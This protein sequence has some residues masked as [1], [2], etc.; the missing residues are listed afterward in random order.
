[1]PAKVLLVVHQQH[2]DPGRIGETLSR[3]GLEL[4]LRRPSLGDP[5]PEHLDDHQGAVIFGGPM[6]ANDDYL[7]FIRT[8]L[9]WIGVALNSGKPFLGICLGA[10]LLARHLGAKV[11]A[12]PNG[13]HEIGYY[14]LHATADGRDFV[15]P[16]FHAFEWHG[17]G[18][19][20]PSGAS[21]LATGRHFPHQAFRYGSAYGLQFH[22]EV[23][24]T[25]MERW[26]TRASHKLGFRGAQCKAEQCALRETHD[27]EMDRWVAGFL[28]RWLRSN[29]QADP[30]QNACSAPPMA[31][32][33]G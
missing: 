19:D 3:M 6:S 31:A 4:D 11:R 17:E 24:R 33:G 16:G 29:S 7:D 25:I 10:Q 20:M 28:P 12:H 5:L 22:P 27:P 23:T 13:W 21:L 9:D 26:T 30:K 2:S 32:A 14:P 8:E 18:F 15:D 1:M